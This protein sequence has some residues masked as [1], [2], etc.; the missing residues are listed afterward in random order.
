[1]EMNQVNQV[2]HITNQKDMIKKKNK[3]NEDII[4]LN[5]SFSKK[6]NNNNDDITNNPIFILTVELEKGKIEKL[7]IFSNSEPDGLA[8]IFCQEH[9]LDDSAFFYLKEKIEYLVEEFKNNREK[10]N[11]NNHMNNDLKQEDNEI[12]M[13]ESKDNKNDYFNFISNEDNSLFNENKKSILSKGI[14]INNITIKKNNINKQLKAMKT[15]TDKKNYKIIN[16]VHTTYKKS[17]SY[18][19]SNF[20]NNNSNNHNQVNKITNYFNMKNKTFND[21]NNSKINTYYNYYT[22]KYTNKIKI[23]NKINNNLSSPKNI[24]TKSNREK[25]LGEK[26]SFI[27]EILGKNEKIHI[28]RRKS[29]YFR[30]ILSNNESMGKNLSN[31]DTYSTSKINTD[32]YITNHTTSRIIVE[33]IKFNKDNQIIMNNKKIN[34]Y[35]QYLYERNKI[36]KKEK[37]NEICAIQRQG[38]LEQY[39]LYSFKPKTNIKSNSNIHSK[40][41]NNKNNLLLYED[42]YNFKPK[43]NH[44]YKTDLNFNQRQLLFNNLYKKRSEVLKQCFNNPKL[45][46]KGNELFKP[47]LISKQYYNNNNSSKNS[48]IFVKNYSY[49]KKYNYNKNQLFQKYYKNNDINKYKICPKEKTDKILNDVYTKIFTKLFNDLDSDQDDLITSLSISTNNIPGHI[50]QTLKPI[51]KELKEDEQTLNCEEFILV[52]IRLF[53]DTPLVD[54]QNL[55]N[56][57]KNKIKIDN[58]KKIKRSQTPKLYKN[59]TF[60]N[61]D[62]M[63]NNSNYLGQNSSKSIFLSHKNEK[64][65]F[66][67]DQKILNDF[68]NINDNEDSKSFDD[69]KCLHRQENNIINNINQK[70]N[71]LMAISR[72]TFNNYLK[73]VKN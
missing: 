13:E 58:N 33:D 24:K 67:Y 49:Y 50:L 32:T 20:R 19:K 52:M 37:Q 22:S 70:N 34:N 1:M 66:K 4:I 56:Y 6:E 54:R 57:Y 21:A 68:Q 17:K 29:P 51:L 23:P 55:I 60:Y 53:E 35:G 65:A 11:I 45:D 42:Q 39:R 73:Q 27:N 44:N 40:Y 8:K 30:S 9:N 61:N 15:N 25:I 10:E 36:T 59:Y 62:S 14:D 28:S 3:F 5:D 12:K 69:Y 64:M 16:R 38:D 72:Y 48:D 46:E 2:S 18:K 7:D 71:G 43:I 63:S 26:H 31:Y 47:K 41:K